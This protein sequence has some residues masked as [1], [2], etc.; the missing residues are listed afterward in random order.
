MTIDGLL[1][2]REV[3]AL[4]HLS[5]NTV[6]R[7][8]TTGLLKGTKFSGSKN[9]HWRFAPADLTDF[10]MHGHKPGKGDDHGAE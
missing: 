3:A 4:L 2:T 9:G 8:A 6:R 1:T 5:A 10:I 7:F